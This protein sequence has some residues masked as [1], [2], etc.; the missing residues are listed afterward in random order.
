L[1]ARKKPLKSAAEIFE[2]YYFATKIITL[3]AIVY[4]NPASEEEVTGWFV[5]IESRRPV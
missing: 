5:K 1:A 3:I 4:E 2:F